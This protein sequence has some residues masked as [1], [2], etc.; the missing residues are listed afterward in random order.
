M[1]F[2]ELLLILRSSQLLLVAERYIAIVATIA[3]EYASNRLPGSF[4]LFIWILAFYVKRQYLCSI[5]GRH[6][7]HWL[8][9]LVFLLCTRTC[10]FL[11]E[12]ARAW[13]YYELWRFLGLMQGLSWRRTKRRKAHLLGMSVIV[14]CLDRDMLA[15]MAVLCCG[16]LEGALV[17]EAESVFVLLV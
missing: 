8:L 3:G 16:Y 12:G 14:E 6:W 1:S 2:F 11:F 4:Q 10:L 17:F 5:P 9:Q 15:S 13:L 7:H